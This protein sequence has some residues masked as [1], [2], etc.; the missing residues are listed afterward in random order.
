MFDTFRNLRTGQFAAPPPPPSERRGIVSALTSTVGSAL[1]GAHELAALKLGELA[2]LLSERDD[3]E[4][5][6]A[7][8]RMF[9]LV[10]SGDA[11]TSSVRDGGAAGFL[12][13]CP[14]GGSSRLWHRHR[15]R[16]GRQPLVAQARGAVTRRKGAG[17]FQAIV[18]R[19]SA[20]VKWEQC[21]A[22]S[23]WRD[24]WPPIYKFR[25]PIRQNLASSPGLMSH[26]ATNR[27]KSPIGYLSPGVG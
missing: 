22:T 13:G 11:T 20:I 24:E 8:G 3:D 2:T 10:G 17:C 27:E 25:S 15:R 9:V 4:V 5:R 19:K 7:A 12:A 14:A 16:P 18:F 6:A 1:V 26:R 21:R 23:L